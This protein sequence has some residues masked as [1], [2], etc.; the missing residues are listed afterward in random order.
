MCTQRYRRPQ[1]ERDTHQPVDLQHPWQLGRVVKASVSSA[2][3]R[4]FESELRLLLSAIHTNTHKKRADST[5][6]GASA[7]QTKP[8]RRSRVPTDRVAQA[9]VRPCG[10]YLMVDPTRTMQARPQGTRR[11]VHTTAQRACA[12]AART[13]G[14]RYPESRLPTSGGP[15]VGGY[16]RPQSTGYRRRECG[17]RDTTQPECRRVD[18]DRAECRKTQSHTTAL[19][20]D[21]V[22]QAAVRPCGDYCRVDLPTPGHCTRAV[23]ANENG[24]TCVLHAWASMLT[25][26]VGKPPHARNKKPTCASACARLE[27]SACWSRYQPRPLSTPLRRRGTRARNPR[28]NPHGTTATPKRSVRSGFSVAQFGSR[29]SGPRQIHER[30]EVPRTPR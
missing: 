28:A 24:R 15:C 10:D 27:R 19:A 23:R 21:G 16:I 1:P 26:C 30:G 4:W 11:Y 29:K 22:A 3:G 9:A 6:R 20:T 25:P 7:C 12:R 8:L 17:E 13:A 5:Q 18:S 2:E 14:R